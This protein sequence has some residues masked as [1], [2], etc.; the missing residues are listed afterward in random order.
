M[1]NETPNTEHYNGPAC[2]WRMHGPRLSCG[3]ECHQ[4]KMNETP[5]TE[6]E[7]ATEKIYEQVLL[8]ASEHDLEPDR[9]VAIAVDLGYS[10]GRAASTADVL[11]TAIDRVKA[12]R[13]NYAGGHIKQKQVLAIL[14]DLKNANH[15][16]SNRAI[17]VL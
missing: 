12:M 15:L 5:N 17:A 11:G 16:Y 10:A 14:E 9:A 7:A 6:R 3:C 1:S 8:H 2:C 4:A 13:L